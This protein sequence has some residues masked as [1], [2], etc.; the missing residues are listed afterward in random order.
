LSGLQNLEQRAKKCIELR[1]KYV[2]QIPRLSAVASFLPRRTKDLSAPSR[3]IWSISI[4]NQGVISLPDY[5]YLE[6]TCNFT[7]GLPISQNNIYFPDNRIIPSR[8]PVQRVSK[9]VLGLQF[10]SPYTRPSRLAQVI[11]RRR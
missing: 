7:S 6:D 9:C 3:K 8:Q 1:G 5:K 11:M 4:S 10:N 2:E